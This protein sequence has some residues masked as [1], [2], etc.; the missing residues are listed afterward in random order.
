MGNP[1]LADQE[2]AEP[3]IESVGRALRKRREELSLSRTELAK[4]LHMGEEQLQ[5]LE[6]GEM[7]RLNEPVFI[8]AMVR[9]VAS[10]LELDADHL[11]GQLSM[12]SQPIPKSF[13]PAI[14]GPSAQ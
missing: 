13:A 10:H 5:A 9:R 14:S 2:S 12:L 3:G 4:R 7:S 6:E 8:K 1:R 11:V